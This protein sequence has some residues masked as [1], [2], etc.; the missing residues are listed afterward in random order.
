M[1]VRRLT[2]KG[3]ELLKEEQK[4]GNRMNRKLKNINTTIRQ[5]LAD[6]CEE[7]GQRTKS[8]RMEM[9]WYKIGFWILNP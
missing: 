5:W 9:F 2:K 7:R 4:L 8:I 1:T 3:V 6:W